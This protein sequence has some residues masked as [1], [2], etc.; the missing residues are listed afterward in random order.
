[1]ILKNI[2]SY[3]MTFLRGRKANDAPNDAPSSSNRVTFLDDIHEQVIDS[4]SST[5]M[6]IDHYNEIIQGRRIES[7]E[8]EPPAYMV[9][10]HFDYVRS[11]SQSDYA[12]LSKFANAYVRAKYTERKQLLL[13]FFARGK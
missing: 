5:T 3:Q 13:G 7:S 10:E 4:V 1:M 9:Q 8:S 2:Q 6:Y 12:K 11:L